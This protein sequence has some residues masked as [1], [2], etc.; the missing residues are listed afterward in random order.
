M[1]GKGFTAARPRESGDPDCKH[2]DPVLAA[3]LNAPELCHATSHTRHHRATAVRGT[4]SFHSLMPVIH[5]DVKLANTR[6]KALRKHRCCVDARAEPGHD[7]GKNG[8][9]TS[10]AKRRQTQGSSA[11]P[12]GHGRASVK[13]DAHICRR[14]TAALARETF[15]SKAQR[16]ARLPGTRQERL[17]RNARSNRGARTLRGYY[18]RYPPS[19]VPVQRS[20]SRPSHSCPIPKFA[21]WRGA[22][23]CEL[24]NQKD[25]GE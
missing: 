20:T 14:S 5:A 8:K 2:G 11:V 3:R 21:Q 12:S 16:Q 18:G 15:V 10:E 13:R 17:I 25:T 22:R 4:A 6:W 23:S 9:E 1:S 7:E 24:R 19:P